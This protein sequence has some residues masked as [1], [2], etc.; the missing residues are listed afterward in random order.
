LG[1]GRRERWSG[2]PLFYASYPII[3]AS[4]LLHELFAPQNFGVITASGE[5]EIAAA[6]VALGLH[7]PE[8]SASPAPAA[9]GWDLKPK[10]WVWPS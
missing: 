8:I 2:L 3:P 7:S 1:L 5:D 10:P 9:R 4:E 6:N